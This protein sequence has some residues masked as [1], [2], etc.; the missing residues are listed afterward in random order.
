MSLDTLARP[1]LSAFSPAITESYP[2]PVDV[3][4]C[5]EDTGDV[6][7][8]MRWSHVS[9]AAGAVAGVGLG[10]LLTGCGAAMP[11]SSAPGEAGGDMGTVSCPGPDKPFPGSF[12]TFTLETH[13][14]RFPLRYNG[15]TGVNGNGFP[16][17]YTYADGR[18]GT[19][20]VIQGD[21]G[22]T[23][24]QVFKVVAND[25][26]NKATFSCLAKQPD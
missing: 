12:G 5:V 8:S 18:H 24:I 13:G 1:D 25:S 16:E 23:I 14:K 11:G 17:G 22:G 10:L 3:A 26:T 6:G 21:A 4:G 20:L 15:S 19:S 7:L 2:Q 9:R